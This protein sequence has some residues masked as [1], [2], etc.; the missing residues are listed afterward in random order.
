LTEAQVTYA[1]E[2][3]LGDHWKWSC[4]GW[5]YCIT[6]AEL[7]DIMLCIYN[8]ND[9]SRLKRLL[10]T[11]R[12]YDD[13]SIESLGNFRGADSTCQALLDLNEC[14]EDEAETEE[15]ALADVK[16]GGHA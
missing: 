11:P 10:T 6:A 1:A 15:A 9:M 14:D 7:A 3:M 12:D 5:A 16:E 2:L 8:D 4:D 13:R